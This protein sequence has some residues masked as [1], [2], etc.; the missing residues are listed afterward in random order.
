MPGWSGCSPCV[1]CG[2]LGWIVRLVWALTLHVWTVG[3]DC[4]GGMSAHP[5]CSVDGWGGPA[6]PR[7]RGGLDTLLDEGTLTCREPR[8]SH[9]K[10]QGT[11]GSSDG[12]GAFGSSDGSG[13]FGSSDGPGAFGIS[14]EP[15]AFGSSDGLGTFVSSY[16]PGAF[17][18]SDGPGEFVSFDGRGQDMNDAGER[19]PCSDPA[20]SRKLAPPTLLSLPCASSAQRSRSLG[21]AFASAHVHT[22]ARSTPPHPS[23]LEVRIKRSALLVAWHGLCERCELLRADADTVQPRHCVRKCAKAGHG[24]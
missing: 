24:A 15:G 2:R 17:G 7:S 22:K 14:D 4:V 20:A 12:P 23:H 13:A 19:N 5:V 18:S 16:G 3:V 11:F 21:T 9:I 8:G 1:R 6:P 10:G